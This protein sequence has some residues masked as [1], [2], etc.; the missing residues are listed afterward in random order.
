M[1]G[2]MENASD[3][4]GRLASCFQHES[5]SVERRMRVTSEVMKIEGL[6]TTQVLLT[7]MK[8]ALNPL[9]IDLFISISDDYRYA[10]IQ[11][12]LIPDQESEKQ[13]NY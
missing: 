10:Y 1:C 6:T 9:K 2:I 12:L 3:C 5:K 4:I 11:D 7:S 13:T 8:I